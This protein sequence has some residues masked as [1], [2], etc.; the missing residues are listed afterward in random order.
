M[1][2]KALITGCNG[3][4]ASYLCELLLSKGY[5][6]YGTIRRS[7]VRITERIDAIFDKINVIYSDMTDHVSITNI[8]R[9]I[10]PDE[11]YHLAAM[12]HVKVSFEQPMYTMATNCDGT[13]ALLEAIRCHCPKARMYFA[14]TSEMY[15]NTIT[16]DASAAID[17]R[18][19]SGAC[20]P[21]E[22]V[23]NEKSEMSPVSPYG[24]SKFAAM[25]LCKIYRKAY[26][27]YIC[28]GILFNHESNRRGKTFVTKKVT[29]F[30]QEYTNSRGQ[31][32]SSS[33]LKLGNLDS[34]RDWGYAK[35]YVRAM[36]LMLQQ[37]VP[38]D[39]TIST[40]VG[41][42]V[43]DLV[44]YAFKCKDIDITFTGTGSETKGYDGDN[45]VV[46]IDS[47]YYREYELDTL[48][49][50]CTKAKNVLGWMPTVSFEELVLLMVNDID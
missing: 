34:I 27:M 45:L 23:L 28:V 32:P 12:S 48:I 38:D 31:Q 19:A 5:T 35:D 49:G 17:S 29:D 25:Q 4:D 8:I 46:T 2:P 40:G 10:Q 50:D 6:V 43:K 44:R 11:V 9:Q 21:S 30:V 15:G 13:L 37:D 41:H 14:G 16:T 22:F 18:A 26:G 39:Y 3:Q 20:A 33:V 7:S 36:F 24:V 42:T 47:R 1:S